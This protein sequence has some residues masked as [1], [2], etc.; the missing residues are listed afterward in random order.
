MLYSF[1]NRRFLVQATSPLARKLAN[2]LSLIKACEDEN[3]FTNDVKEMLIEVFQEI[4]DQSSLNGGTSIAMHASLLHKKLQREDFISLAEVEFLLDELDMQH[5]HASFSYQRFEDK[6]EWLTWYKLA[7]S[8]KLS[9]ELQL[10]LEKLKKTTPSKERL[11]G[12]LYAELGLNESIYEQLF[13]SFFIDRLELVLE[14]GLDKEAVEDAIAYLIT[15]KEFT[16]I[17]GRVWSSLLW[18][19]H[20]HPTEF[21]TKLKLD[22]KEDSLDLFIKKGVTEE[23]SEELIPYVGKARWP[24][25]KALE[26]DFISLGELL[27]TDN[28]SWVKVKVHLE[29][30]TSQS[31]KNDSDWNPGVFLQKMV[32]YV[33]KNPKD[34]KGIKPMLIQKLALWKDALLKRDPLAVL[35]WVDLALTAKKDWSQW[36]KKPFI[37][38]NKI[39]Q[40]VIYE[41]QDDLANNERLAKLNIQALELNWLIDAIETPSNDDN[42]NFIKQGLINEALFWAYENNNVSQYF[43]N[44]ALNATTE[45]SGINYLLSHTESLKS[46]SVPIENNLEEEISEELLNAIVQDAESMLILL[47]SSINKMFENKL[48]NNDFMRATHSLKS[49]SLNINHEYAYSLFTKLES[50]SVRMVELAKKLTDKDFEVIFSVSPI[51]AIIVNNWKKKVKVDTLT[52]DHINRHI[53]ATFDKEGKASK[54]K[55]TAVTYQDLFEQEKE[56]EKEVDTIDIN[57]FENFKEEALD[58]FDRLDTSLEGNVRNNIDEINRLLHT[59]KGGSRISG[60][61]KL[62]AWAHQ[63]EDVTT[64][65]INDVSEEILRSTLEYAFDK[66][67]SIFSTSVLDFQQQNNDGENKDIT[68]KLPLK[69]IEGIA[70]SLLAS[71]SAHKKMELSFTNLK[72]LL[73]NYKEPIKRLSFLVSEV[74]VEAEGL[75]NAGTSRRKKNNALFDA[76]EMDKFTYFH[77]LTRKLEEAVA[78]NILYNNLFEKTIYELSD[79]SKNG[80]LWLN[81]AQKELVGNLNNEAKIYE[82]RLKATVRSAC[83]E[84]DKNADIYFEGSSLLVDKKILDEITPA[85]EHLVRNSVAHSIENPEVRLSDNKNAAGRIDVKATSSGDWFLFSVSD[86]GAGIDF[87]K[88]KTKALEKNLISDDQQITNDDLI[89]VMFN[90]GF[91]T[92][93][94]VNNI[95]GR[96]VGLDAVEEMIQK[97]GGHIDVK[98]N[99]NNATF[100]ISVPMS[101]WLLSG[102]KAVANNK[103]YVIANNQIEEISIINGSQ[104]EQALSQKYIEF[105]GQKRACFYLDYINGSFGISKINNFHSVIHLRNNKSIIVDSVEFVEKQPIK[106][107]PNNLYKDKGVSGTTILSDSNVGLVLDILS[108]QWDY[109][110]DKSVSVSKAKHTKNNNLVLVVDDSLTIRRASSKFL[111]KNGFEVV[112]AENGFEAVQYIE[113]STLPGI[114][115]M[116]I[117]MPIMDGFEALQRIK[118]IDFAKDIPVVIISSRAVDKHINYAK[119]IGAIDF[120]GKPFN[121]EKLL[122]IL[123]QYVRNKDVV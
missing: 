96:G 91:S 100:V 21:V 31:V 95:A 6:K 79:T 120:L 27:E 114:I 60:L 122:A 45:N 84:L 3:K 49:L 18:H 43:A 46:K 112:T 69:E 35:N 68:L 37:I 121:E 30:I 116:D 82:S 78:D 102:V 29:H 111:T 38:D 72:N 51:A 75:L 106:S 39:E 92:A 93:S 74:Y 90:K 108:E 99:D 40:E 1:R 10:F 24:S 118:N 28:I 8:A 55:R 5:Y 61:M 109:L 34:L 62:G 42:L 15:Q 103:T 13:L 32:A 85:L 117:E 4:E 64:T 54:I 77:E 94:S 48:C 65:K 26:G 14:K 88:I 53:D 9:K 22:E 20:K 70:D 33:E 44:A 2:L 98:L 17:D 119:S 11:L 67:R 56:I 19:A 80:K 73:E 23:L 57:I 110:Y 101:L 58:I 63:I 89:S 66:A 113:N 97:V 123:D 50:W 47:N 52:I 25:W 83:K 7:P 87:Q 105:N 71:E 81:I 59:L 86:D 12:L 76:L 36:F 16:S 41:I 115:L 104:V 107:L